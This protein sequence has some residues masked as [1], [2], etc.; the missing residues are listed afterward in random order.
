MTEFSIEG[1]WKRCLSLSGLV[2]Q[3]PCGVPH[4]FSLYLFVVA[5]ESTCWWHIRWKDPQSVNDCRTEPHALQLSLDV[6]V[7]LD[8]CVKPLRSWS[9]A[10]TTANVNYPD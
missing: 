5:L 6:P 2:P 4:A 3:D 10:V 7:P 9:F 1:G 8:C